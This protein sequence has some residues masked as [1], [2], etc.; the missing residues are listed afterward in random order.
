VKATINL[1]HRRPPRDGQRLPPPVRAR[2]GASRLGWVALVLILPILLRAGEQPP[3]SLRPWAELT[4]QEARKKYLE[5]TNNVE[6]AWQLGRACFDWGEFARTDPQRE[7]IAREGIGVCRHAIRLNSNSAPAHYYLAYN[8]G[9]L[10]RTRLLSALKLV[11][12]ME[13]EFLVAIALDPAFDYAGPHRSLGTL[14]LEAP[15]WPASVGNRAKARQ[16][17]E[18]AAQLTPDF[19]GNRLVLLEAYLRWGERAKAQ[20]Q[21]QPVEAVLE[22]ARRKLTGPQWAWDWLQWERQWEQIRTKLQ[23][24][25]VKLGSPRQAE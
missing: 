15:G 23:A 2:S 25:P 24:G 9:Q 22:T 21:R 4:V 17:L 5:A 8:L 1:R 18:K 6:A 14:Y 20:A 13:R 19:P 12:E 10:A 11:D 3:A 7:A 16:H